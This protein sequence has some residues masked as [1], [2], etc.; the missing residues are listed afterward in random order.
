M[1]AEGKRVRHLAAEPECPQIWGHFGIFGGLKSN[2]GGEKSKFPSSYHTK[3]ELK[4]WPTFP[5]SYH[6][7]QLKNRDSNEFSRAK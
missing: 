3:F 7:S 1:V 2:M 5:M 4:Q 6:N